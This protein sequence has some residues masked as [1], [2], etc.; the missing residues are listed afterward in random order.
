MLELDNLELEIEIGNFT[1][2]YDDND[3]EEQYHW[4]HFLNLFFFLL[5][6]N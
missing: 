3:L 4:N 5:M 2:N 6:N 1:H